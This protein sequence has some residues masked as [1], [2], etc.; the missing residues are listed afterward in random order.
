[1]SRLQQCVIPHKTAKKPRESSA[2][3]P[4][5]WDIS[6][7]SCTDK[8]YVNPVKQGFYCLLPGEKSGATPEIPK[9]LGGAGHDRFSDH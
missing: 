6:W 1:M 7:F 3:T 8:H 4:K 5:N 9:K 2:G